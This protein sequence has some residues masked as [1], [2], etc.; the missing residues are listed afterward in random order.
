LKAAGGRHGEPRDFCYEKVYL[1]IDWP[2]LLMSIGVFIVVTGLET[3]VLTPELIAGIGALHLE[4]GPILSAL[5][6][7]LSNL[8]SNVPAV[9]VL[10]PFIT[11]LSDPQHAWLVIAMASTL[12]GNFTLVGSAANLIVAQRARSRGVTFGFWAYFKVGAPLTVLTILFG[13]WWL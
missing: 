2:L 7:L 8:V 11:G 9:L 4:T 12:A 13:I 5:T 10:K 3:A 6:A 1:E